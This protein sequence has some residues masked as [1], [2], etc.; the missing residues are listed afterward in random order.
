M[1]LPVSRAWLSK[2]KLDINVAVLLCDLAHPGQTCCSSSSGR[3]SAHAAAGD[4]H[5]NP[6]TC[7]AVLRGRPYCSFLLAIGLPYVLCLHGQLVGARSIEEGSPGW[8]SKA[9]VETSL[10]R[11]P[12]ILFARATPSSDSS[13][14]PIVPC[15]P[16]CSFFLRD[17]WQFYCKVCCL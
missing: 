2:H 12:R 9:Q 16:L 10:C 7:G 17:P 5:Q 11:S 6:G 3:H 1:C 4:R 13:G 15:L 14:G 8:V